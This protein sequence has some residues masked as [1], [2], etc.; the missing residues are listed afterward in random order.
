M[1]KLEQ[2]LSLTNLHRAKPHVVPSIFSE[3]YYHILE[4][5]LQRQKLSANQQYYYSHYIKKKIK[6]ML[7][8]LGV[9]HEINGKEW[10]IPRRVKRAMMILQRYSRKHRGAKIL[11]SGSF[12]YNQKHH[13]IDLFVIS[14]YGKEDYREG[15]IHVNY[16]PE[17]IETSL[18]FRSIS[19]LSIANFTVDKSPPRERIPLADLLRLYELIV[20]LI[21]QKDNY[22]SE[23]RDF[24]VKAE[25][26]SQN[27]V[28]NTLQLKT[29][30]DAVQRSRNPLALLNK[31]L[32]VKII[33]SYPPSIVHK[34]LTE[35]TKKN[36]ESEKGKAIYPNWIIYN[37]T[38][39]E[40]L[41]IAT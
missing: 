24:I 37:Q 8:I 30:T 28:L 12:L 10:M 23:L 31:Y 1:E 17:S 35:F 2:Y 29:I 18:F 40:A 6:G 33:N 36:R 9:S 34:T 14:K 25:Y 3:N 16:L 5:K 20:L 22:L 27:V 38:Y 13:D 39:K 41:E 26:V 32:I 15:K 7:E 19:A 21:M 4:A 11:V